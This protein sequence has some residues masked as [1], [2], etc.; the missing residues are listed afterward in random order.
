MSEPFKTQRRIEFRDTDAAGIMHFS[1]FFTY[2]EQAEHELLRSLGLSVMLADGDA[3][4]GWP[5]VSAKCDYR[6][7]VRFEELIDIEVSV[8]HLGEKSVRYHHVFKVDDRTV[9]AG[10]MTTVCCRISKDHALCSI[11]I[12]EYIRTQLMKHLQ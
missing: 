9:A 8:A 7:A 12:P 2:M 10:E 1:V 11:T 4:I 6:G 3:T 5:R